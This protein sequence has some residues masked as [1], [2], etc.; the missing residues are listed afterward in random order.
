MKIRSINTYS[1]GADKLNKND[2]LPNSKKEE[3]AI[4]KTTSQILK[5][6]TP[7]ERKK[8]E[9]ETTQVSKDALLAALTAYVLLNV[10]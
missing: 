3:S 10:K 4:K 8:L 9:E 1:F 2:S 7:E 6:M 5:E